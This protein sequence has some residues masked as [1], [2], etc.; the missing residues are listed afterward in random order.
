[1]SEGTPGPVLRPE[2]GRGLRVGRVT[3]KVLLP[4]PRSA[5]WRRQRSPP[6]AGGTQVRNPTS[7]GSGGGADQT[8]SL[9]SARPAARAAPCTASRGGSGAPP[10]FGFMLCCCHRNASLLNKG[11]TW[12]L[13]WAPHVRKCG[14][15]CCLKPPS[16]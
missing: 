9:R 3:P 4:R 6:R 14:R 13:R 1:M 5:P 16:L 15:S 12:L 8:P 10:A 11:P 2:L 7:P